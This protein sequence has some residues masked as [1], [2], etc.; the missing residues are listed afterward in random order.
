[1][2]SVCSPN[3]VILEGCLFIYIVC[4]V[5]LLSACPG[6]A[7]NFGIS[8]LGLRP[9]SSAPPVDEAQKVTSPT[10]GIVLILIIGQWIRVK[11]GLLS[12]LLREQSRGLLYQMEMG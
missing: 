5:Y 9:I 11:W 1:M 6:S 12:W 4:H 8:A 7:F 10:Q 2:K 3:M